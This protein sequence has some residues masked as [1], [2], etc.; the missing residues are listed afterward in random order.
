M[1]LCLGLALNT[2]QKQGLRTAFS[3]FHAATQGRK[4]GVLGRLGEDK[5]KMG[6]PN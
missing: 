4:F 3:A 6:D 2:G 5:A 1:G